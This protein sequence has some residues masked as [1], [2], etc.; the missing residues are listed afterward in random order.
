MAQNYPNPFNPTT[1][2]EYNVESSGFVTLNV[3]DVVGRLVRT[4]VNNQYTAAGNTSGYKVMWDGLD[5]RGNQV[6]AGLYIYRLQSGT[7]A[8][9]NKMIL[10]K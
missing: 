3:Y 5:N 4:L 2:I 7:M 10:L 8:T 6:S 9:T 1:T